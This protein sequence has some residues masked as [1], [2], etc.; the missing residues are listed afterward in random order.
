MRMYS[1]VVDSARG[2]RAS[3][4]ARKLFLVVRPHVSID[5]MKLFLVIAGQSD[6]LWAPSR[7]QLQ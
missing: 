1:I 5:R 4:V 2:D 7:F 6:E 3:A